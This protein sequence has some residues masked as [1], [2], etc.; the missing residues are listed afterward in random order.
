MKKA[1]ILL[2]I[3]LGIIVTLNSCNVS[4]ANIAD[5]KVCESVTDN[6]CPQDNP[7][8]GTSTPVIY[9]SIVVKNAPAETPVTF[10]WYYQGDSRIKID[11]VTINTPDGGTTFNMQSSLN[12]PNNGWPAGVYEVEIALGTDNSEPVVKSFV[13]E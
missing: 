13:I 2:L 11:A 10:T 9:C 7:M 12:I 3:A 8:F 6:Q 1:T 5:V 4:T